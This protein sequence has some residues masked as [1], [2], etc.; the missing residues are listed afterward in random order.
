[1]PDSLSRNL[2]FKILG[3]LGA[4]AALLLAAPAPGPA[5][6]PPPPAAGASR[7]A[8]VE[9]ST[10]APL[11]AERRRDPASS[12]AP[13][14]AAAPLPGPRPLLQVNAV[15]DLP[16]RLA[17]GE[18]AWNDEGV[19]AGE[20]VIV[21]NLAWRI[22]SVYRSGYEIGRASIIYGDDDKPTPTGIFPIKAKFEDHVSSIYGAP[23]PY[24]LRLTDDG[25]SIHGAT[26][27]DDVATHGCV[28]V[29][30]EFAEMLFRAAQRGDRVL[31]E[32]GTRHSA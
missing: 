19:P 23:M 13:A 8:D 3:C 28:G 18:Y 4:G 30:L 31:I 16:Q 21:V 9:M 32:S 17:A 20:T 12:P 22:L 25:I 2:P 6:S 1:M 11:P 14:P 29:P 7:A 26:V 27:E 5:Q 10:A 24:T 15:L